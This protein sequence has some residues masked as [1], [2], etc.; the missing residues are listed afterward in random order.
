MQDGPVSQAANAS[1]VADRFIITSLVTRRNRPVTV[2]VPV[3]AVSRL[4]ARLRQEQA[5]RH[6]SA[7]WA[8]C[9]MI[10]GERGR[11]GAMRWCGHGRVIPREPHCLSAASCTSITSWSWC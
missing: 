10:Y 1:R 5:Q 2:P 9:Q 3:V 8:S 6:D 4:C 7:S 11:V